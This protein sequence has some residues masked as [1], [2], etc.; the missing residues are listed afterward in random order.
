[1]SAGEE[2]YRR[3]GVSA[4]GVRRSALVSYVHAVWA[5][6]PYS[7]KTGAIILPHY[8]VLPSPLRLLLAGAPWCHR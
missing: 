5:P 4:F 3:V 1:V 6:V 8:L 2:T 7:T